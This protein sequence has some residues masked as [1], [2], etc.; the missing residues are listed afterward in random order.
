[1][2]DSNMKSVSASKLAGLFGSMVPTRQDTGLIYPLA[3]MVC[4]M[5]WTMGNSSLQ[6]VHTVTA[7]A[8]A[9]LLLTMI[10]LLQMTLCKAKLEPGMKESMVF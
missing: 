9:L 5:P 6:M 7:M 10:L 8:G 2:L 3:E 1:M 4:V